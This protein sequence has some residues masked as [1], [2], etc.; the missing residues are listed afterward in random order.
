M[1]I[2]YLMR[3]FRFDEANKFSNDQQ[4]KGKISQ[5]PKF[6]MWRGR[7]LL[8]TGNEQTGRQLL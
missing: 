8:Y 6:M 1:K 4:T 2:E 5:N 3:D 7:V